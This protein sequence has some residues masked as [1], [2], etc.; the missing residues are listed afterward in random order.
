MD[1]R[2]GALSGGAG[3]GVGKAG[4]AR[5]LSMGTFQLGGGGGSGDGSGGDSGANALPSTAVSTACKDCGNKYSLLRKQATCAVCDKSS[6]TKCCA[7]EAN[8]P[9]AGVKSGRVCPGCEPSVARKIDQAVQAASNYAGPDPSQV[10]QF[11]LNAQSG[12]RSKE[13]PCHACMKPMGP[14]TGCCFCNW[15]GNGA[16]L[17]CAATFRSV[18]KALGK[19]FDSANCCVDCWPDARAQLLEVKSDRPNLVAV[20]EALAEGAVRLGP[21]RVVHPRDVNG[22]SG[23]AL[24][25]QVCA[26]RCG[27]C[28]DV[29]RPA[30]KCVNCDSLVCT[31]SDCSGTYGSQSLTICCK[32]APSVLGMDN[33]KSVAVKVK[34]ELQQ[35]SR[36]FFPSLIFVS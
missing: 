30:V 31:S 11:T 8:I 20:D 15:C 28:F 16:C 17:S 10:S 13:I 5:G 18:G 9:A 26:G 4:A 1:L 2:G 22:M 35:V 12:I 21:E 34:P 25:K 27:C 36:G 6:C 3:A 19:E 29:F 33:R 14:D 23:K 32:C 24:E 7:E